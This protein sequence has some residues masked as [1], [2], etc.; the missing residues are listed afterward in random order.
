MKR[1]CLLFIIFFA[2]SLLCARPHERQSQEMAPLVREVLSPRSVEGEQIK[3]NLGLDDYQAVAR[4]IVEVQKSMTDE[5]EVGDSLTFSAYILKTFAEIGDYELTQKE[6]LSLVD[7]FEKLTD[8]ETPLEVRH[9]LNNLEKLAFRKK[10]QSLSVTFH[11]LHSSGYTME[12][13]SENDAP[14]SESL[15]IEH[16][17]IKDH[18]EISFQN[19]RAHQS[20]QA[21]I[22]FLKDPFKIPLLPSKWFSSLNQIHPDVEGELEHYLHQKRDADPLKLS[23]RGF[24]LRVATSTLFNTIDFEIQEAFTTPGL[25]KDGTPLPSFHLWMQQ[26]LLKVKASVTD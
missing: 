26:K 12:I 23:M 4:A 9:I 24:E 8:I 16:F 18:A 17:K 20:R 11:T 13:Y 15:E 5:Y 7:V 19:I 10:G 14:D 3:S 25:K 6:I 21:F 22:N 1:F 2:N